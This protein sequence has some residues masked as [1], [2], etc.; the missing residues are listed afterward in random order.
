MPQSGQISIT[1][2]DNPRFKHQNQTSHAVVELLKTM[3]SPLLGC[4]WE[5]Y[6]LPWVETHGNL[7]NTLPGF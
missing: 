6:L 7:N 5:G 3:F 2:G 4:G 1:E